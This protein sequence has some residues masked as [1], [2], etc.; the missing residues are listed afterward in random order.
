MGFGRMDFLYHEAALKFI[1]PKPVISEAST[2]VLADRERALGICFPES[3]RA[4][5]SLDGAVEIL[6]RCSNEDHPVSLE[7]LGEPAERWYGA[8][9][10]DLL[11]KSLPWIMAENQGVC[12]WAVQ[13]DGTKDPPVVVEVN[14]APNEQWLPYAERFS[15][16]IFSWIWDHLPR[17]AFCEAQELDLSSADLEFLRA[18]FESRS[19]TYSWP[20]DS[21][22]R[23]ES[24]DGRIL[25]W[26]GTHGADWLV[27]AESAAGLRR[28]LERV[29]RCGNLSKTLYGADEIAMATLGLIRTSEAWSAL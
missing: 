8:G 22:H 13:L 3:I 24:P 6:K 19:V 17:A 12:N 5:Y 21:N 18:Q 4:W 1:S 25:I 16:F 9:T 29:W 14:T 27:S 23:F 7:K 26:Q 2:K 28:V 10:R 15:E 11:S 20:G